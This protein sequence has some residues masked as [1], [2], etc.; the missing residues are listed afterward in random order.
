MSNKLDAA[1]W[2]PTFDNV[3]QGIFDLVVHSNFHGRLGRHY[4]VTPKA[5]VWP[6]IV[7]TFGPPPVVGLGLRRRQP[8]QDA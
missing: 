2:T 6:I 3:R 4:L 5:Y 8:G 7:G 1:E